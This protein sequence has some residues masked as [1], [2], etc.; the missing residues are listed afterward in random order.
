M[1]KKVKC[2]FDRDSDASESNPAVYLQAQKES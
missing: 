1:L 2:L